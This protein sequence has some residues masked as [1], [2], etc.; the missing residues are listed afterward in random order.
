[1]ALSG[2]VFW[3]RRISGLMTFIL[4]LSI[5]PA[6]LKDMF[7]AI[8]YFFKNNSLC[9]GLAARILIIGTIER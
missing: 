1:M 6:K 8:H 4:F 2:D 3:Q 5:A 9:R 7:R